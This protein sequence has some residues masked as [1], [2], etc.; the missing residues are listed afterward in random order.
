MDRDT[1]I[2][3]HRGGQA[4]LSH[5]FDIVKDLREKIRKID[6]D[7]APLREELDRM[8]AER[9][10]RE[11]QHQPTPAPLPSLEPRG[12]ADPHTPAGV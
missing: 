4:G 7:F 6:D 11:A 8:R 12:M 1:E 5:L 3:N 2:I 10:A 9:Q